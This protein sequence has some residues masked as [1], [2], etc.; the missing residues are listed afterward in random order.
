MHVEDKMLNLKNRH[1]T[2]I[3]QEGSLAYHN[4]DRA[5]LVLGRLFA[6]NYDLLFTVMKKE[7]M[8]FN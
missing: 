2:T 7:L 8:S 4:R 1:L 6:R 3:K 5:T